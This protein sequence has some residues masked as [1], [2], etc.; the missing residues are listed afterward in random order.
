MSAGQVIIIIIFVTLLQDVIFETFSNDCAFF[1]HKNIKLNLHKVFII[2]QSIT[3]PFIIFSN[4]LFFY[5]KKSDMLV[6]LIIVFCF[7][8]VICLQIA[9]I[10]FKRLSFMMSLSPKIFSYSAVISCIQIGFISILIVYNNTILF[11]IFVSLITA[12][13]YCLI[14]F[15]L[16]YLIEEIEK[17]NI[18]HFA[19]GLPIKLFI[20]SILLFAIV[21][22]F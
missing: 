11:S 8:C 9:E 13:L 18:P 12:F 10:V 3:L 20:I 2:S 4:I 14:S 16:T 19:K 6:L 1:K 7:L 17:Q 15:I 22:I 21:G 5:L